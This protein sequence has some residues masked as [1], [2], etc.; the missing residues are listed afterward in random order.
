MRAL[1]LLVYSHTRF[2]RLIMAV[3]IVYFVHRLDYSVFARKLPVTL[4][5]LFF[6][7]FV[8]TCLPHPQSPQDVFVALGE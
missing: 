8:A 7:F 2:I 6:G 4:A 3:H 5:F 1:R